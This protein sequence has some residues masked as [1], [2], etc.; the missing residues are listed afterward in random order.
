MSVDFSRREWLTAIPAALGVGA[1]TASAKATPQAKAAAFPFLYCLN[2]S[3]ISGQKLPISE[4]V[5]IAAKAGYNAI[6]PWIREIEAHK[7]AGKSLADLGKQIA[8]AGL[9]VE[10]AIGFAEWAVDDEARRK[11]GLDQMKREMD[12]VRAIGGKRIAAPPVGLTDRREIDVLKLAERYRAICELGDASGVVAQAELWG[13]SKTMSRLGEVAAIVIES[14][15]R[16]ACLLPDV[17]HLYKGGSSLEGLKLLSPASFH[18]IHM[19]DYPDHPARES[20]TDAQRVYPGDGIAP[21]TPLLRDLA[22]RGF[23]VAL[24]LEVFNR[25]YWKLDAAEV[26][27]TGLAKL[28]QSVALALVS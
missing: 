23:R 24:S 9:S 28:K 22:A 1:V 19:N 7:A 15:H 2:T 6:E 27:K 8:D 11:K 17:F 14:G 12:L 26:A 21:L 10:S 25:D 5:A 18:V 3:T 20:I 4:V 13:F 16:N